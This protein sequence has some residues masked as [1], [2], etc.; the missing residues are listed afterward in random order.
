[1][2]WKIIKT[3]DTFHY[4]INQQHPAQ[5]PRVRQL[6]SGVFA[7]YITHTSK[8]CHESSEEI[9]IERAVRKRGQGTE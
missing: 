3:S 6:I 2:Q 1:M 4:S 7:V 5:I 9:G 8:A